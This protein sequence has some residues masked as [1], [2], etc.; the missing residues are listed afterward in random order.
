MD[1]RVIHR[2]AMHG[3]YYHCLLSSLN[4][5]WIWGE[6]ELTAPVICFD[7]GYA[8]VPVTGYGRRVSVARPQSMILFL[9][10]DPVFAITAR[11]S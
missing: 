6:F 4:R 5:D 7:P 3:V 9:G 1:R 2:G 11:F 8:P 10:F